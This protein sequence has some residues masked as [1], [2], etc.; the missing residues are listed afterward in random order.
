[1]LPINKTSSLEAITAGLAL[2][3]NKVQFQAVGRVKITM[4]IK[5][6]LD[7]ITMIQTQRRAGDGVMTIQ[8][9]IINLRAVEGIIGVRTTKPQIILPVEP[10]ITNQMD[11]AQEERMVQITTK[12]PTIAGVTTPIISPTT[13]LGEAILAIIITTIQTTLNQTQDIIAPIAIMTAP[14]VHQRHRP[15]G[16]IC[17]LL[18]VPRVVEIAAIITT[19]EILGMVKITIITT[20]ATLRAEKMKIIPTGKIQEQL[21]ETGI[22]VF[23]A[24]ITMAGKCSPHLPIKVTWRNPSPF[25]RVAQPTTFKSIQFKAVAAY[26]A[27]GWGRNSLFTDGIFGMFFRAQLWYLKPNRTMSP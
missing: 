22:A 8:I 4:S 25:F 1:M 21:A 12:T 24:T 5:T 11:G 16:V 23:K 13:I 18:K 27:H 17:L 15:H 9:L 20:L 26:L 2:K 19:L 6:G 10:T 14:G 7:G 3:I